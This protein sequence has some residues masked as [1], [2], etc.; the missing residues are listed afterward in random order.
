MTDDDIACHAAIMRD[1]NAAHDVAIAANAR[2]TYFFFRCSVHRHGFTQHIAIANDDFGFG[3]F[4]TYVLWVSADDR[5]G[6]NQIVFAR[7]LGP[8][9]QKGPIST[10]SPITALGSTTASFEIL[11]DMEFDCL[12]LLA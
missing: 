6:R 9:T 11:G 12:V 10:S 7:T 3:P 1:M 8:I 5:I 2:D 4:I